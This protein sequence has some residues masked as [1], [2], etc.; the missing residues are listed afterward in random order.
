MM[1]EAVAVIGAGNVGC[2]LGADLALRGIEVRLFN[3]S[4]ERLYAI[5]EAGGVVGTGAIDGFA[6]V[7]LV[8]DSLK[9]AVSGAGVIFVTLPTSSLP[10]YA[11]ALAEA[12]ADDQVICLNPGHTG[13]ALFLAAQFARL[14]GRTSAKLCQ[15]TTASHIS[16]MTD[17]AS[18]QVFLRAR[19]SL[20]AL[21][22]QYLD[23]C[24]ARV[25][26][27]LPGG[28]ARA[29]SILEVD[30]ANINALLHP[31]G[32]VC[33]AGWIEARGGDFGF[34]ADATT[35]AVARVIEEI[36]RERL[37][38]A[39][40]F[41]VRAEP[42]SDLFARLGFTDTPEDPVDAYQAIRSSRLIH[43]IVAPSTLDHRYLHEDVGWGL[44]PWMH[45]AGAAGC[46]APTITALV[47]L[48]GTINGIDYARA[49]ATLERLGLAGLSLQEIRARVAVSNAR[50]RVANS[51]AVQ[52][53]H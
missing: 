42:F 32:M 10:A 23:E 27:L 9:A 34:Y 49:G 24:H 44:V 12:T 50:P 30:L 46:R 48:S 6:R 36:D 11:P 25:E 52:Q 21:P 31:P 5:R 17:G 7:S 45:L 33:N 3:R 38:I 2:A 26:A 37:S 29:E 53:S 4:A 15:L 13:G 43:P 14:K 8:T 39:E 16:R 20:A 18:V 19:V 41:E 35:P 47:Q 28:L 51:V 1:T 22:A 40:R